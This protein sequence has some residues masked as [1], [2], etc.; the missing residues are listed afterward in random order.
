M[1]F[2]AGYKIFFINSKYPSYFYALLF[3]DNN[4]TFNK[5]N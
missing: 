5:N 2:G 3:S 1:N 4:K